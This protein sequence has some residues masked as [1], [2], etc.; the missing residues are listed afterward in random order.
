M[1]PGTP[2]GEADDEDISFRSHHEYGRKK[3]IAKRRLKISR[4]FAEGKEEE[5]FA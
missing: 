5:L 3:S 4:A 1:S 2:R